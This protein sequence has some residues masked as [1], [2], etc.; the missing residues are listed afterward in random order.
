MPSISQSW[1]RSASCF[2]PSVVVVVVTAS[3]VLVN[4]VG[5]SGRWIDDHDRQWHAIEALAQDRIDAIDRSGP[6][7]DASGA[8]GLQPGSAVAPLPPQ[9]APARAVAL[10][11]VPPLLQARRHQ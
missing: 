11:C 4:Q 9:D 5:A 6:H 7:D 8:P 10:L 1:V 2:L 3:D